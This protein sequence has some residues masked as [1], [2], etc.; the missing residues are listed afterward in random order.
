MYILSEICLLRLYLIFFL[1]VSRWMY[2][3][4]C[5]LPCTNLRRAVHHVMCSACHVSPPGFLLVQEWT[6]VVRGAGGPQVVTPATM[7]PGRMTDDSK[8]GSGQSGYSQDGMT[9]DSKEAHL[10][11]QTLVTYQ[12][13]H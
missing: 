8:V 6:G 13:C 4:S 7:S 10:V 2:D 5:V 3:W 1:I 12:V 9:D 11:R